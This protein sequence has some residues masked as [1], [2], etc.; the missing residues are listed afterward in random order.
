MK[1]LKKTLVLLV[2]LSM[3]LSA[4][5]PVFAFSDVV[6]EEYAE[7]ANKMAAFGV[8]AGDAEGNF[9]AEA[10]ITRRSMGWVDTEH[11]SWTVEKLTDGL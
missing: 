1:S 4:V 7:Q 8:F 2:V 6:A 5:S 10:E 11:S 9:N 3:I